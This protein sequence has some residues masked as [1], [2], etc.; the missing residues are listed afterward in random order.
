MVTGHYENDRRCV[1]SALV[2]Y[3]WEAVKDGS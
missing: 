3:L 1:A 2:V